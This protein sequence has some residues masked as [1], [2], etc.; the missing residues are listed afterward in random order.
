MLCQ[1]GQGLGRN[2]RSEPQRSA[3]PVP[4]GALPTARPDPEVVARPQRRSYTAEYKLRILREA[5]AAAAPRGAVGT[6]LRREGRYSSLLVN[7]RRERA[8]GMRAALTP[9]KRGPQVPAQSQGGRSA[10]T[11]A[12]ECAPQRRAAPGPH[13]PRRLDLGW[14]EYVRNLLTLRALPNEADWVTIEEIR[15][16]QQN[17]WVDSGSGSRPSVG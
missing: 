4:A 12:A 11:A 16:P 8:P 3:A 10:E 9:Q 15:P 17:L 7:W 1:W 6:L 13:H 2:E 14:R 5:E